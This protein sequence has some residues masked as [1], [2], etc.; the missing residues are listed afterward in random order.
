[1]R[2]F[3]VRRQA[4]GARVGALITALVL[5]L[6]LGGVS[7]AS[8]TGG[9]T[10]PTGLLLTASSTTGSMPPAAVAPG[11]TFNLKVTLKPTGAKFSKSTTL[12]LKPTLAS[13]AAP[14]GSLSALS[15]VMPANV[16]SKTFAISY[17][18]TNAGV[19]IT[20]SLATQTYP[21]V[22]AGSTQP[23]DVY[24]KPTGLQVTAS[25]A[26]AA[27]GEP[28]DIQVTLVPAGA[29]FPTPT[30]LTLTASLIS[31][32][33][34]GGTLTP[35]SVV[36][37]AGVTSRTFT[38]AY[39]APDSGVTVTASAPSAPPVV[40]PGSTDPIDVVIQPT[41]LQVTASTDNA[42][43]EGAVPDVLVSAGEAF[44]LTVT[45]QPAG[46]EF[47]QPTALTLTP[48]LTSGGSPSGVLDPVSVVMPAGTNSAT[49]PVS[50][51]T[52][53]NGVIVTAAAA[54]SGVAP[55]STQPFDVQIQL[56]TFQADD[57]RLATGLGIGDADCT[58]A[59]TEPLCGTVVLANGLA[60]P[61][62]ALSLGECTTDLGC[63]SGSQVVQFVADLGNNY[64]RRDPA[65][66]IIRCDAA[67][68]PGKKVGPIYDAVYDALKYKVA[69]S[70]EATG[71]L[72]LT[73]QPCLLPGVARD[74]RGNDYCT[75]L[76]Q[77]HRDAN[78]DLLLYVLFTHDMRGSTR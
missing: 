43:I 35:G 50:Y 22:A 58:A 24:A 3:T 4:T 75:D 53:D 70:F 42:G 6:S 15:V 47:T 27:P 23:F 49:F 21:A 76:Y 69:L 72:S 31:G 5:V 71:P 59:T 12:K 2:T 14:S 1:M 65:L 33:S 9:S 32:A 19:I 17:S 30:T 45:L 61:Q 20:A 25:T 29:V 16:T 36:M 57:P 52:A 73:S 60:S 10:K 7:T 67:L 56:E 51:S 64:S 26:L 39:S 78:G 28:F 63:R 44:D 77:S 66:L 37:P 41:A 55:G 8:A 54:S 68:C 18:A 34:P 13:G 40:A 46:A 48:T 62:G 74:L 11:E 38:V